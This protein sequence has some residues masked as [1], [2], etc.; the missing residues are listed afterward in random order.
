MLA[1]L[2]ALTAVTPA[3]A[4]ADRS[5]WRKL[6]QG[7]AQPWLALQKSTGNYPDFTDGHVPHGNTLGPGTR[8]GDSV[9]A[10]GLL[11]RGIRD[12]NQR[13]IDSALRA[14]S[15]VISSKRHHLQLKKPSVFESMAVAAGYNIVKRR[16][17]GNAVFRRNKRAW[18]AW[19]RRVRPVSTILR[20]P[21]TH[22]FSNHYL[23]E[24][25][26]TFELRATGVRT[27]D[28][29][30]LV[31]P[32][33]GRAVRIYKRMINHGIPSVARRLG[34]NRHGVPT[35]LIGDPP[36]Y[37]LAYQG[38]SLGFYAQA[39]RLLGGGSSRAARAT[40]RRA[41]NASW[42]ISSPDG[43]LGYFGRSMEESWNQAGTA[44]GATVAAQ[45]SGTGGRSRLRYRALAQRALERLRDAYGSGPGGYHFIPALEL[46]ERLGTRGIEPYAGSP[47]FAGLTLV[48]LNWMVDELPAGHRR[49]GA[50]AAS[51]N[52]GTTL[53]R[54]Q[55]AFAMVRH[56]ASWF[57]VRQGRS[58]RRYPGDL[59]YDFGLIALKHGSGISWTNVMPQ[60]PLT[61]GDRSSAGPVL[62]RGGVRGYPSGRGI[63]ISGGSVTVYGGFLTSGGRWLR[64]GVRF[65]YVPTA[66]GVRV[67][68]RGKRGDRFEY[69]SFLRSFR[70]NPVI[71]RK[72]LSDSVQ[73]VTA[74]PLP[75][76][77]RTDRKRYYSA[78]D[79]KLR[80]ARMRFRLHRAQVISITTCSR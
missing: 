1:A 28:H 20:I 60:R 10:L 6:A 29:R 73:R 48:Q 8:Y 42:L 37:P 13:E 3:P 47:S 25:I 30:A 43:D 74:S 70:Q 45:R 12:G 21:N 55:S 27:R 57:A 52:F 58:R 15:W 36:D 4:R 67:S 56:G 18:R 49:I 59:R 72:E 79:P 2:I 26:E 80:R 14:Y 71:G 61:Y 11:Q 77:V 19:L 44:L 54:G 32:G 41:T 34:Q 46:S 22:R 24:A 23:I 65:R 5:D 63:K 31:G 9:L 33:L 64:R 17:P 16:L 35:F 62:E 53:S 66:C 69:S 50:V 7:I 68:V 39:I 51:R 38:L 40:L 75:G 76:V 78:T